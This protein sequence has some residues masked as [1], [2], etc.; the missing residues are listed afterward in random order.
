[1]TRLIPVA[2]T[3]LLTSAAFSGVSQTRLVHLTDGTSGVPIAQANVRNIGDGI[4]RVTDESGICR[5]PAA[6]GDSLLVTHVAF[7]DTV[8]RVGHG[9]PEISVFLRPRELDPVEVMAGKPFNQRAAQGIQNVPME[10]L[11][12]VP[13]FLGEP[14]IIKA[15]TFLPGV[16]EGREGYSHLFVRGGDQ[17]Q[18]LMLLDG[19]TMFNVNHFGGFI[20]MFHPE[21]VGGVDFYKSYW[22]SRYGGRLSSVLDIRTKEGNYRQ[23]RQSVEL[24]LI[25]PKVNASG[26]IWKDRISYNIGA[27]RTIA[28]LVTGPIARRI[29]SGKKQGSIGNIAVQ[30]INLRI[31][32]RI[33]DNQHLSFSALHGRDR[34][35][36]LENE[37]V[38]GT[39]ADEAYAIKN[40]VAALNYRLD[41]GQSTTLSAHASFSRYRHY[42]KDYSNEY[43]GTNT[44]QQEH[45]SHEQFQRTGNRVNSMKLN[46]NGKSVLGRRWELQYGIAHERLDYTIYMDREERIDG[47]SLNAFNGK[48]DRTGA[49]TTAVSGDVE[50]QVASGLDLHAGLRVSRYAYG[51][52][53]QWLPEPK[54]LATYEL[55]GKSTVN[56]AFNLQWQHTVLL[57]FLDDMGRFRE[58]YVTS[59][60][61]LAPSLSRQWSAGYFRNVGGL[62]DNLSVE[63]FYKDQS[64]VAKFLP[65]VDHDMDVLRYGDFL[66]RGG[67]LRAYG[68]EV[69]IQKTAGA[70]HGSLS[71]TYSRSRS[72]FPTLNSGIPFDADFDFRH[73]ANILLMYQFGKGYRLS[74]HWTYKTGRPFTLPTS[75]SPADHRYSHFPVITDINNMRLPAF[76]RLDLNIQRQWT[77]K[78]GKK[79]WFGVG[80]YN[81]YNRVN[82]FFARPGTEPGELE[83]SGMFSIIPFFHIGFEP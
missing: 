28:D 40:E 60:P 10:F 44:S 16:V 50:Y 30:D 51:G 62:V 11:T 4:T 78:K 41:A 14:D 26:P 20:S 81:A 76:H 57:G 83:I 59:E 37:P 67:K 56:A 64:G 21:M 75:Q 73:S 9:I 69:F 77:S 1:M 42:Y 65:S 31:D 61:G 38:Y 5:I 66:H 39:L 12:S 70:L 19:A 17:D 49:S 34:Y 33:G 25:A 46:V 53:G 58:F 47:N 79:N 23:H 32:G 45:D 35:S 27:R 74:G 3:L 72:S 7:G 54:L 55:D 15:L 82:P 13:A 68:A 48:V 24:G 22:P 36:F 18:N 8:F 71:Y 43:Q 29:R 63:L 80:V 2:F 6:D 52:Y